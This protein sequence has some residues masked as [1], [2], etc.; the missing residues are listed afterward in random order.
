MCLRAARK[1][2]V[3]SAV[4]PA[5]FP[6][7]LADY[8]RAAGIEIKVDDDEFVQRRR[9]KSAHAA[10]GHPARAEGRG[11]GDGRRRAR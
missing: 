10:R 5:D 8:F 4:V 9:V 3:E 7:F 1:L 6:V 2:D 11:R